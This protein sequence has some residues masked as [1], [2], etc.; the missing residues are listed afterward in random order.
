MRS[1]KRFFITLFPISDYLS[2]LAAFLLAYLLRDYLNQVFILPFNRFL[3]LAFIL[4]LLWPLTFILLHLYSFSLKRPSLDEFLKI[5]LGCSTAITLSST[6]IYLLKE[7]AFSRL[8]LISTWAIS[9]W[10]V[11]FSRYLLELIQNFL[12][13]SGIGQTR[14]LLVGQ[15]KNTQ[16]V[17]RGLE[18]LKNPGVII[19][20]IH[21]D[22][23]HLEEKILDN[24][25]TEVILS[26]S[27][28]TDKNIIDLLEICESHN[29]LLKLAPDIFHNTGVKAA[30]QNLAGIPLIE[31]RTSTLEGWSLIIKRLFDILFSS[32]VLTVGSPVLLTTALLIKLDSAGSIFYHDHRIGRHGKEFSCLK[33][34][35][36]KMLLKNGELVHAEEDEQTEQLKA[37]QTNYKL[38]NDPR[39]T[40]VGHFIRKTSIDELPQFWN[41]LRGEMSVVGPRP[42][43]HIELDQQQSRYPDTKPLVRRLL[44]VNPGITCIWQVSGRSLV[45]FSERV[46]MDAYYATNTSLVEDLKIILRTVPVV[47]KGSGAM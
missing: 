45:E 6:T 18:T 27:N 2:A 32:F 11:W 23:E 31:I 5:I 24:E 34:R 39:I 9:V 43:K 20:G 29:V 26:T 12:Y 25:V 33:F 21:E 8:V 46:A 42:Y 38:K 14:I 17:K 41:V 4:A 30:T 47:I 10:L 3:S 37:Q 36:M 13:R 1:N 35:S 16:L 22:L 15:P 44:T 7:F 40:R 19:V 28:I